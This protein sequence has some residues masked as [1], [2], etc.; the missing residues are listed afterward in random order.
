MGLDLLKMKIRT[1]TYVL[2]INKAFI[3]KICVIFSG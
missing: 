2:K 1:S 3:T